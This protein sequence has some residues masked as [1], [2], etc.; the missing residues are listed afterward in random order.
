MTK[1]R[2]LK[3]LKYVSNKIVPSFRFA[4]FGMTS[5]REGKKSE[6]KSGCA[7]SCFTL[8]HSLYSVIPTVRRNLILIITIILSLQIVYGQ[9]TQ[10]VVELLQSA[11]TEYNQGNYLKTLEKIKEIETIPG[12]SLNPTVSYLKIMSYYRLKDYRQCVDAADIY[13]S[14]M[15][16]QDKTFSEIRKVRAESQKRYDEMLIKSS[17]TLFIG[18]SGDTKSPVGFTVSTYK[19][20]NLG[21]YF[22]LRMTPKFISPYLFKNKQKL[23]ETEL[24][25]LFENSDYQ[26]EPFSYL[27]NVSISGGVTK[28]FKSNFWWYGGAGISSDNV[29][30][31]VENYPKELI[32]YSEKSRTSILLDA[33]VS[34]KIKKIIINGGLCTDFK[35]VCPTFGVLIG[36]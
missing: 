31:K 17:R 7:A 19:S 26:L 23:D 12:G 15:P 16:V 9:E 18:Y 6:A 8:N 35:Y 20:Q 36:F 21:F 34:Y 14:N 25:N 3:I 32:V 33:G 30:N 22:S 29:I 4:A 1:T 13:L 5:S 2:L 24:E 28:K 27:V 10:T 11:Q